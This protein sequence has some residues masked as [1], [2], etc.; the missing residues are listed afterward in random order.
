MGHPLDGCIERLKR[1]ETHIESFK[2]AAAAQNLDPDPAD[3]LIKMD[4]NPAKT[5]L[6]LKVSRDAAIPLS[7]GVIFGDAIHGLHATLDNLAFELGSLDGKRPGRASKFPILTDANQ[8]FTEDTLHSLHHVRPEHRTVIESHQPFMELNSVPAK[9]NVLA[10]IKTYSNTDKHRVLTPVG[11]AALLNVIG[12][13]R[14]VNFEIQLGDL[15]I[16][17]PLR[18]GAVLG[19]FDCHRPDPNA[20][21]SVDM[22]GS[23]HWYPA[24]EQTEPAEQ[25]LR[26]AWAYVT[27]LVMGFKADIA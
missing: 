9:H 1:V 10:R 19:R 16:S 18:E 21:A 12:A 6:T 26:L 22:E 2:A 24:I 23:F 17:K 5:V 4:L 3:P 15:D 27:D 13:I 14:R 7:L 11:C 25:F 20:Q 8:W